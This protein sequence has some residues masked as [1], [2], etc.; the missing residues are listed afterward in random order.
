MDGKTL[1]DSF[2]RYLTNFLAKD[3]A[4]ATP[5]D[6]YMALAY[7]IRNEFMKNWIATQKRYHDRNARRVY[8]LSTE[9]ILGK[10]LFQNIMS[11][12]IE[13]EMATAVKSLGFSIDSIYEQED[14]F[15]LGNGSEARFAACL[16]ESLASHDYPA[17]A[18]GLRYEFGQF[19]Q[20]IRNGIQIERPNDWLRKGNPWEIVR[21]EYSH[22]V[23]FG[24]ECRAHAKDG[25]GVH[26]WNN[27]ESAYAIPY[28]IPIVGFRN[29]TVNTLRLWTARASEE[30]LPDYQ[31]H[32][33]YERA[34]A[35]KSKYSDITKL[36]FPDED[37][38]RA[39][40][41]RMRQQYFFVS[42]SL[43]DIIRRFKR[44]NK[45]LLDLDK[46]VVIHLGGSRCALAIPEL[47]RILVDCEGVPWEKAWEMTRNV[48]SYTS[49][50]VFR[51][52]SEV[53]PVYKVGQLLPRHLQ[54]IFD[55]NQVH[56]DEVRKKLG[57]DSSL[58]RE[59]SLVEEGEVKRIRFADM[60]VLGSYSVNGVSREQTEILRTKVFPSLSRYCGE[61]FSCTVNGIGLRRWLLNVNRPLGLHIVKYI[62]DRWIRNPEQLVQLEKM[63]DDDAFLR[64]FEE[65]KKAAK[66]RLTRLLQ[67]SLGI[68]VDESMMFDAQLARIHGSKRQLLHL[69]YLLHCYLCAKSGKEI[70]GG[71]RRL[72]IFS[73]KASPS[74]FLAKQIIYLISVVADRINGDPMTKNL[75]QAVMVPDF[76]ISWAEA[77]AP[78]VDLSE[79]LS[80][81]GQEPSGM[82]AMKLA[83]NGAVSIVSLSGATIEFVEKVGG[84]YI[85]TFGKNAGEIAAMNNYRPADL[86]VSDE[87]LRAIFT[88]LEKDMIP[89]TPDGHAIY[90]LLSTLRDSDRQF[91][92]LDFADYCA[93]QELVD[94][95]YTRPDAW[96]RTGVMNI[97]RSGWF[98]S[99]RAISEYAHRI[100]NISNE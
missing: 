71:V 91:V 80:T 3:E 84:E 54:V 30:F 50:A 26:E 82:F 24:G 8:Y 41:L 35:D 45:S 25:F 52:D 51:E 75:M 43:Q 77:I 62:G 70:P 47:M 64:G 58:V 76:S 20:E 34:Y 7:A 86:L 15:M 98:S 38:R 2:Y 31:N 21:P 32:R 6:R 97:A 68:T 66:S 16:L 33:D 17:M 18:Y 28:D 93:K 74:D 27:T 5:F 92:L 69:L 100:W 94:K 73:G 55:I 88:F 46:K 96:L 12:G 49:H 37:V 1:R 79:H 59:L 60:A 39:T 95:L 87:R 44:D 29:N 53:W 78:A 19:R 57:S 99:D 56:L 4:T 42:A 89:T 40:D 61:R 36:L 67:S 85:F 13:H 90:P 23:Q 83:L 72:H 10:S 11:L 9:Y 65:I 22:I 14:D 81:A 48:F 63:A